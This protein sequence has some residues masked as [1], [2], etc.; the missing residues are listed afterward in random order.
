MS[1]CRFGPVK[2][3]L[4]HSTVDAQKSRGEKL[5]KIFLLPSSVCKAMVLLRLLLSVSSILSPTRQ[6]LRVL[7][8][9][10]AAFRLQ[11]WRPT[12]KEKRGACSFLGLAVRP[13]WP[14]PAKTLELASRG[15]TSVSKRNTY[16]LFYN[17][18]WQAQHF[19][20]T[21]AVVIDS[22]IRS[23]SLFHSFT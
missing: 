5:L 9:P 1:T 13:R 19:M 14:N 16:V 23:H 2:T 17:A 21:N 10:S 20:M 22:S 3:V 12:C 8:P 6:I 15:L 11:S 18:A 4:G 7:I